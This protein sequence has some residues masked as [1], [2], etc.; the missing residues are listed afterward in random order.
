RLPFPGNVRELKNL[1]ERL[2][3]LNP[4]DAVT[5]ADVERLAGMGGAPAPAG[6]YRPGVPFRVLA[7]EAERTI[8]EEAIEHWG[9]QMAATARALGLER[10][11]LYKKAK[12]LG[13]RG[14]AGEDD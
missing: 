9:G 11:H 10:S 12:A 3:I 6:L 14:S 8:L 4:D 7:E 2:V 13:L 5:A 1:I